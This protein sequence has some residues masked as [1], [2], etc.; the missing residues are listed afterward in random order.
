MT[1]YQS[2]ENVSEDDKELIKETMFPSKIAP[3]LENCMRFYPQDDDSGGFF[4]TVL[5]KVSEF[6]R[7]TKEPT[8]PA[9][10]LREAP[11]KC[12]TEME[13]DAIKKLKDVYDISDEL[14]ISQLYV[15]DETKVHGIYYV[16]QHISNLVKEI[17]YQKL[18][19]IH[20]G[21]KIFTIKSLGKEQKDIPCPAQEGIDIAFRF[22]NKRK[23]GLTPRLIVKLLKA[24]RNGV[25]Y[26][27]L[28]EDI[29]NQLT[30]EP[31]TGAIFYIPNTNF[32]YSGI[33]FKFSAAI[34]LKN[35]LVDLEV[36]KIMNV[37][38]DLFKKEI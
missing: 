34:Y 24:G 32:M 10:P 19:V 16:N 29:S 20:G 30:N 35:E 5:K 2:F 36:Q 21:T 6:E 13:T 17:G 3:G 7:V 26:S 27:K 22:I 1:K 25:K 38:S 11:F 9:K 14:S 33:T 23:Y 37:F 31:Q 15:R 12:I 28:P 8:K 18:R 4:I